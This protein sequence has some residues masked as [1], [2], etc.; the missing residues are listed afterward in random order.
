MKTVTRV[1]AKYTPTGV[2]RFDGNAF[3]EALP[4]LPKTKESLLLQL[5]NYPA[6]PTRIIRETSEIVRTMELSTLSDIVY[7]FPDYGESALDL[8]KI[9]RESYVARNPFSRP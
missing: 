9:I 8:T 4:P 3:I 5:S 2:R 1:T 6:K 7:P